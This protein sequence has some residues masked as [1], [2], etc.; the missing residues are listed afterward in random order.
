[1]AIAALAEEIGRDTG[2]RWSVDVPPGRY[3]WTVEEFAYRVV[4]EALTNVRKHS[5]AR[6]FSVM[7]CERGSLLVGVVQDD[8]QG[9]AAERAERDSAN[10]LGIDGMRERARL[11]GGDVTI[12]SAPGEGV[13]VEFSFP[14]RDPT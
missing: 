7:L 8:G 6:A 13:R 14:I 2:A 3:V 9:F 1:V 5:R 12:T 4:R 10:H 11:A